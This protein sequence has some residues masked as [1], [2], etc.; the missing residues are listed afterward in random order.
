MRSPFNYYQV[1]IAGVDYI[2]GEV[3]YVKSHCWEKPE[4]NRNLR[5]FETHILLPNYNR[6]GS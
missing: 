4:E 2:H 5:N 1:W 3:V 6:V